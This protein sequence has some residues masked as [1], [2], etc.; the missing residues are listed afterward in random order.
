MT[1]T[2]EQ[3]EKRKNFL[4]SSDVPA[5]FNQHLH[6]S[7][8]DLWA[9]KTMDLE[10]MPEPDSMPM[11]VGNRFEAPIL[12]WA[13]E[14]LNAVLVP[15]PPEFEKGIFLVHPDAMFTNRKGEHLEAKTT[16]KA[17]AYGATSPDKPT[18][19]VPLHVVLQTHAQMWAAE[20][21]VVWVPV[22][23]PGYMSQELCMYRVDR[24]EELITAMV[25][26][27]HEWWERHVVQGVEPDV[28]VPVAHKIIKHVKRKAD[29][30][31]ALDPAVL[32]RWQLARET[33]LTAEKVEESAK[34]E[35]LAALGDAD[36]GRAEGMEQEI[37]YFKRKGRPS[38]GISKKYT[39]HCQECGVGIR[40]NKDYRSL[41]ERKRTDG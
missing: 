31:A 37:T 27:C 13:A 5:I 22:L 8:K 30:W 39:D 40:R 32:E 2:P 4:G 1:L 10:E 6:M 28:A 21:E 26:M 15:D 38:Y 41:V 11:E 23:K 24:S 3:R 25:D 16:G 34:A 35:L 12:E 33:R 19:N 17:E 7:P 9:L 20:T 36:G 14:Q 29:T 18:D